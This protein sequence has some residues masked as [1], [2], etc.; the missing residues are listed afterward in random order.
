MT[1][2]PSRARL[3]LRFCRRGLGLALGGAVLAQG[4]DPASWSRFRGPNGTGISTSKGLPVEFGPA[5]NLVWR[6]ELPTGHSSPVLW[7][8]SVFVTGVD[9]THS[10]TICLNWRTGAVVWKKRVDRARKIK[11][12]KRNNVASATAA[13]SADRVVAFFEELGL[14]A[15]DH[16]GEEKW[17]V[18]L[19]PFNNIYGM[20]ASPIIVGKRVFQV[21]DQSTGSFLLAL[22]TDDGKELWRVPRNSATS[23]H[24]TPIVYR[25]ETGGPQLIVPGS[26]LL[27][28][29]DVASGKRVWWVR[30]LSFEMKSTP[31]L[32]DG[33][34]YINGY[35]SP[36]N[37]PGRQ[38]EV[39]T[40]ADALKEYGKDE[41]DG[42]VQKD[43]PRRLGMFFGAVDL[44]G[45]GKLD[46]DDWT[47]FRNVLASKNGMLAIRAGGEGDMT[48]Q[49]VLWSYRRAVPQ[50]PSP[51]IYGDVLY[52]LQDQ[53]GFVTT[54]T[55]E[56]ELRERGRLKEAI[57]SYYASPVAAD[58]KIYFASLGGLVTVTK[59][60]GSLDALAVNDLGEGCY[61]TPAIAH[62]RI[63]IR[64]V[65]ALYC[66]GI[67]K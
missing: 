44:A 18:P 12:D 61:A 20:G 36:F 66:F 43:L 11:I 6:T 9:A 52:M 25:P 47:Y 14:I 15:Y 65:K 7:G 26:F 17:R 38:I 45:D 40:F 50:L 3:I 63:F 56:G 10:V 34:I 55:P 19:G 29:Y 24:C 49:S 27:D 1:F 48:K 16:A 37:Q 35:G 41:K 4:E 39:P 31:A 8:D 32:H 13:V 30:G 33:I 21:C 53:S 60:G 42:V 58:G 64:T 5:K 59:Q 62:D 51:L 57:D 2:T 28:A 23:G 46:A 67:E 22:A 54:M